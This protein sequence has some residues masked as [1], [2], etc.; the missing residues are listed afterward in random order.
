MQ[1]NKASPNLDDLDLNPLFVQTDP[2]SHKRYCESN[3]I[4]KVPDTLDQK[5][6]PEIEKSLDNS[7]KIDKEFHIKNT[8]RAVGTRISHYLYKKY[9]YEKLN[10][11]FLTLKFKGSAGQSFG[12]FSSKGLKLVL[13]GDS[14]DYVG[15]G[16]SGATISIKLA[17]DSN[18][19]S[20]E[21]TIIGNTVLYGATSGKLYAAGQ[22]GDRFA[23]RNSGATAVVEGCDSNG[24][25]YMT[26]GNIVILGNI[27][28]NFG[29]GMT[30]GMAFIYDKSKS[31]DKKVN[32]ESVVWQNVETDYWKKHLKDLVKE[33]FEETESF[34][35]E[36]IIKN[37]DEEVKN[38]VQVCQKEMIGK[39]K[40]PIP[41]KL[42]IQEVS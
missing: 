8:N 16:L 38:F 37:F 40:Y 15:K 10:D 11:D 13:K 12:A 5:I 24:C 27:G 23:V 30:G 32:P 9:G 19:I 41:S 18:L 35:S 36:N 2:G 17:D 4:N 7:E 3:S 34:L 28:D 20:N 42:D 33:H 22:A 29:A 1:V 25:E 21:N 6:W 39:L 31:F 26:G 14:N